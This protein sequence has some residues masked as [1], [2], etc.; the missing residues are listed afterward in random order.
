M[1]K[2]G[3]GGEVPVCPADIYDLSQSAAPKYASFNDLPL[4]NPDGSPVE[5]PDEWDQEFFKDW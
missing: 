1:A 4:D 5:E 2:G 3:R